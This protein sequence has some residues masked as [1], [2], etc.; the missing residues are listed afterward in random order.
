MA[1][2]A[3]PDADDDEP[4]EPDPEP[5]AD[6]DADPEVPLALPEPLEPHPASTRPAAAITASSA[7]LRRFIMF[8]SFGLAARSFR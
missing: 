2:E 7:V 3:E 5:D 4:A 1:D 6:P 8:P